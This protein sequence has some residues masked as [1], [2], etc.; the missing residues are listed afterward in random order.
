VTERKS[1]HD[2]AINFDAMT[3]T[4]RLIASETRSMDVVV[5]A[6]PRGNPAPIITTTASGQGVPPADVDD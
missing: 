6:P 4:G 5:S 2:R 3:T 1:Q